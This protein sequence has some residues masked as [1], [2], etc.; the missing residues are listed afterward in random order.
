MIGVVPHQ[1]GQVEG[2][3]EPGLTR[4]EEFLKPLVGLL[5][6][7]EPGKLPHGPE[8]APVHAGLDARV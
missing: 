1:G 6:A 3:R 4:L 7:A 5:G 2:G 8:F